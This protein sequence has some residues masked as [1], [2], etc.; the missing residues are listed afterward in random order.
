M[1]WVAILLTRTEYNKEPKLLKSETVLW[2]PLHNKLSKKCLHTISHFSPA[3]GIPL[4]VKQVQ[5]GKT[6][7]H[8]KKKTSLAAR[9]RTPRALEWHFCVTV[10]NTSRA[11]W[12]G[13]VNIDNRTENEIPPFCVYESL[14]N[15]RTYLLVIF[16]KFP[17]DFR[18]HGTINRLWRCYW[19]KG[20]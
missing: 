7:T 15:A 9:G 5:K 4:E 20:T 14:A 6:V 8:T 13:V 11:A 16:E 17:Q 10:R 12:P 1:A 3:G 18:T 19:F 2:L